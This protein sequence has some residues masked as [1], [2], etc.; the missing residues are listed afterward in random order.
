MTINGVMN[1]PFSCVKKVF[2]NVVHRNTL[3]NLLKQERNTCSS[4]DIDKHKVMLK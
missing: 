1:I 2:E 4:C 3:Q